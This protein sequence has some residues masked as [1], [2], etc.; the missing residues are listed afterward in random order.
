MKEGREEGREGGGREEEVKKGEK[1]WRRIW[2]GFPGA[3]HLCPT[4]LSLQ[5]C[6]VPLRENHAL[7]ARQ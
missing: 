1:F 6:L 2:E 3:A 5:R 4:P 7:L